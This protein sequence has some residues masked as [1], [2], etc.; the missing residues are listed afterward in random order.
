MLR[1]EGVG[2]RACALY[3]GAPRLAPPRNAGASGALAMPRER[4][5]M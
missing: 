1:A 4:R 3:K 5:G 2:H